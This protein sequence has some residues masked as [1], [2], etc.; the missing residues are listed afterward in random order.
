MFEKL[1]KIKIDKAADAFIE[2]VGNLSDIIDDTVAK[3][4]NTAKESVDNIAKDSTEAA[5][6]SIDIDVITDDVID[7]QIADTVLKKEPKRALD[8]LKE[9][10][11]ERAAENEEFQASLLAER[12]RLAAARAAA[13]EK[14]ILRKIKVV[15]NAISKKEISRDEQAFQE[16]KQ[17]EQKKMADARSHRSKEIARK[18]KK[19]IAALISGLM[20]AGCAAGGFATYSHNAA[21]AEEYDQAVSYIM[22]EEYDK[23]AGTL[24]E[25]ETE[26]SD[27]L[28]LYAYNQANIEDYKGKPEEMLDVISGINEIE[29]EEVAHQQADAC[30]EIKLADEI[31]DDIDS[32][33]LSTVE[34]ISANTIEEIDKLKPQLKDRYT[35][36]IDTEKYDVASKVLF[37]MDNNTDA[38]K[39]LTDINE[40][41][42]V[43]LDSKDD[44]QDLSDR[45]NLLSPEDQKTIL[46]YSLLTEAENTYKELKKK[47]DERIAAEKK[48]KKEKEKAEREAKEKAEAEA[49]QAAL[50]AEAEEYAAAARDRITVVVTGTG[51]YHVDGC[52]YYRRANNYWEATYGEVK[53]S[54]HACLHCNPDTYCER[55]YKSYKEEYVKDHSED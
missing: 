17:A 21:I 40:I 46:N 1:K 14:N 19:P 11:K 50:E 9:E 39:L 22:A 10:L 51:T 44:L 43:T 38:A 3:I 33:D 28:Y 45:Y 26:D 31:Q 47:E 34:A 32:L 36:L 52:S 30:E 54:H 55:A 16:F 35:V 2:E 20:V 5:V 12:E 24:S 23:A 25:L 15:D 27:A 18:N 8:Y 6:T 4:G 13:K 53:N 37:N 49:K 48:A 29:N 7:V 42:E 41:G